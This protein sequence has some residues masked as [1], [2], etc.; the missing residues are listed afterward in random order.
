MFGKG[1]VNVVD[2]LFSLMYIPRHTGLLAGNM[3]SVQALGILETFFIAAMIVAADTAVK[4]GDLIEP[5]GHG[6]VVKVLP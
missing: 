2:D 6:L 4:A 3:I 5:F 1:D